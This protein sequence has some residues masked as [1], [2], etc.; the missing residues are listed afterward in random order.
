[1]FITR[2]DAQIFSVSFGNGRRTL[3]GIGG[4][5]GSWELWAQPFSI[6]SGSWRTIGYDH[7]G[8]GATVAAP[9]SITFANLLD[10]LFSVLDAYRVETCV[11][12]AE[13]AGTLTALGAA[14][15]DPDRVTG[16]VLVD[17]LYGGE[18]RTESD[19]FVQGLRKDYSGFLDG[20]V[21]ACVPEANSEH[22]KRWGRQ[23]LD[24]SSQEAAIA[25]YL[26]A[27]GAG[28]RHDLHRVTQR[29]LLIHGEADSVAS[30]EESRRMAEILPNAKL[31]LLP[32]AGHVPTMTR[33]VEVARAIDV[34]F[35]D[36]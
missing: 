29:T 4:W 10:D 15:R 28:L 21:E 17:G 36:G 6:L 19:P 7:R 34:F 33:P 12:A 11:L 9:E 20:F 22:I 32:G 5:T 30:V 26:S 25:L 1:M 31:T 8:S 35:V 23:I 27:A 24:R 14:L 2:P 18:N 13:S 3:V 16:L